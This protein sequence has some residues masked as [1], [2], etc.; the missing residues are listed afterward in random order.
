MLNLQAIAFKAHPIPDVLKPP[1]L[2]HLH[3]QRKN[4]LQ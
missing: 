2:G 4:P 3:Y 1:S